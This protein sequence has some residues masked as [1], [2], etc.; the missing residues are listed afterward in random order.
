VYRSSDILLYIWVSW[1]KYFSILGGGD[2]G[3]LLSGGGDFSVT[4]EVTVV[5]VSPATEEPAVEAPDVSPHVSRLDTRGS[6]MLAASVVQSFSYFHFFI[7]SHNAFKILK[8]CKNPNY[9]ESKLFL[10]FQKTNRNSDT[11]FLIADNSI[12]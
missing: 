8:F 1:W 11:E 12:L 6:S 5:E 7:T 4:A 9:W 10:Y 2:G 3:G